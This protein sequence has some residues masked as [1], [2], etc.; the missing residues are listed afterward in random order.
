MIDILLKIY[1]DRNVHLY[2]EKEHLAL[3]YDYCKNHNIQIT[4]YKAIYVHRTGGIH[5]FLRDVISFFVL[6]NLIIKSKKKSKIVILSLMPICHLFLKILNIL[7]KRDLII[8]LHGELEYALSP[9]VS[10]KF[11]SLPLKSALRINSKLTKY[12]FLSPVVYKNFTSL[13]RSKINKPIV[14]DHPYSFSQ[15][16]YAFHGSDIPIFSSIGVASIRKNS[17]YIFLLRDKLKDQ[18]S[19]NK[20]KL[21]HIG[22]FSAEMVNEDFTSLQ[23]YGGKSMLSKGDFDQFLAGITY[24]L[25]F[26]GNDMY[27]LTASGSILDAIS[28]KKPIIAIRNDYFAHYFN[29]FGNI[30]YLVNDLIEMSNIIEC[31]IKDFPTSEYKQQVENL[32]RAQKAFSLNTVEKSI[33][34]QLN[35]HS[36]KFSG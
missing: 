25:F 8:I 23:V 24:A 9:K 21:Q 19:C 13:Y 20:L 11:M 30:G 2:C 36:D 7:L 5:V 18:I 29:E 28:F 34:Q 27:K 16:P 3:L 35:M 32:A 26:Y 12:I 14:I 4:D 6:I 10:Y 1:N 33:R 31:I 15:I 22:P 17:N